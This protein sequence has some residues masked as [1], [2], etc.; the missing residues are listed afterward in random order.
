MDARRAESQQ[1]KRSLRHSIRLLV[2][3]SQERCLALSRVRIAS[4]ADAAAVGIEHVRDAGE[5]ER[6]ATVATALA[7]CLRKGFE[8][9]PKPIVDH[10]VSMLWA[11]VEQREAELDQFGGAV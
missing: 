3:A 7:A 8:D 10:V 9:L 5:V 2:K 1:V 6:M 4:L 11:P